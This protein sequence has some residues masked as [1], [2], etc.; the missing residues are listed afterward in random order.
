MSELEPEVEP[1]AEPDPLAP[2]EQEQEEEEAADAGELQAAATPTDTELDRAASESEKYWKTA[3]ANILSKWG[4]Y[5]EEEFFD[6]PLCNDQHRGFVDRNQLGRMPDVQ[7]EVIKQCIGIQ[8]E[9]DYAQDDDTRE[10]PKCHGEGKVKTGSKVKTQLVQP[11]SACKGY[12]YVPPPS[13]TGSHPANVA[14]PGNGAAL[15]DV[16]PLEDFTLG[17]NDEF[18][19]PRILP[20]GRENPNYG[21]RPSYKVLV[22]PWGVTANLTAQ[23]A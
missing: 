23:N 12:G 4:T 15:V 13:A 7:V 8:A 20:D 1:S 9:V 21:K 19:E 18:G 16:P 3:R 11:C 17:D 6:C 14:V 10:C 22:E 2:D 5:G